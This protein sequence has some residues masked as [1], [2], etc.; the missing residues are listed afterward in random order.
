MR[1]ACS[2]VSG[3][4]DYL[5]TLAIA[6]PGVRR[7][8]AATDLGPFADPRDDHLG[9]YAL[10]RYRV[11]GAYIPFL[12]V[13]RDGSDRRNAAPHRQECKSPIGRLSHGVFASPHQNCEPAPE[14]ADPPPHAGNLAY[15]GA[16]PCNPPGD[17]RHPYTTLPEPRDYGMQ[18]LW[19]HFSAPRLPTGL[20]SIPESSGR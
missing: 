3:G 2:T 19:Q 11:R 6:L 8:M 14:S 5:I 12:G 16:A 15:S 1:C 9:P 17:V 10:S 18:R 13:Y 20:P 4:A 7:L